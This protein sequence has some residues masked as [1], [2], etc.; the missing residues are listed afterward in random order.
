VFTA[1]CDGI[2]LFSITIGNVG[3][4]G[5]IHLKKNGETIEYAWAGFN[6]GWDMGGV[7]TVAKLYAGYDVWVEGR[8]I[9]DGA[10]SHDGVGV[11]KHTGFAG[12]LINAL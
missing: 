11:R 7:T 12:A 2:Y 9:I 6:T 8:G 1:P 10:N 4:W 5:V 3:K